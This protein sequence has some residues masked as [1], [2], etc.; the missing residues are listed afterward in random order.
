MKNIPMRCI[1]LKTQLKS[2]KFLFLPA[3]EDE[4]M[5]SF[6]DTNDFMEDLSNMVDQHI[7]DFIHV[8]RHGW[9]ISCSSFDGDPIYD[10]EG[11]FQV[12]NDKLFPP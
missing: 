3:H 11:G 4:E 1:M 7:D 12:K 9:D 10:I 6:N 8:G 5:V 2:L